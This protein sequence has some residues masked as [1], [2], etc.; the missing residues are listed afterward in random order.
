MKCFK[1]YGSTVIGVFFLLG[2]NAY[3]AQ[4]QEA[5]LSFP[6]L[7][8]L[9][10]TKD[11]IWY[12][13]VEQVG[14]PNWSVLKVSAKQ[15]PFNRTSYSSY[16]KYVEQ[17]GKINSISFSD[18]LPL[19]P[20][21]LRLELLDK[22][23]LTTLLNND[24]H[25]A[26]RTYISYNEDYKLIT[27]LNLTVPETAMSDFTLAEAIQLQ[28]DD[29]G[30]IQLVVINGELESRY[31]FSELQV[32]GYQYVNFCWGEDRYHNLIIKNLMPKGERCPKGTYAKASKV[33]T[34]RAYL[35]F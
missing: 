19:K 3:K 22:L 27:G 20:K 4:K 6:E 10:K 2:C 32:F 7:G 15:L 14:V 31:F 13:A 23:D 35:K 8:T 17:A 29:Y 11:E 30:N 34:D 9:I 16:T 18:S 1:I 33:G 24:A 12:S 28:K 26:L 21:Y 5:Q 25:D